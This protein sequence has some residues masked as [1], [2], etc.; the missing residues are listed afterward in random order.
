MPKL[1]PK[2]F[3]QS[4]GFLRVPES[5]ELL[6]NTGIHPES[7][8]AARNLLSILGYGRG[9][10]FATLGEKL[11]AAQLCQ[12]LLRL[13]ISLLIHRHRTHTGLIHSGIGTG[14][15]IGQQGKHSQA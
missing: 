6:D 11:S 14:S 7:Y 9:E 4:A 2:A 8:E 1:G 13:Q 10:S 12:N 3:E 5:K 15:A